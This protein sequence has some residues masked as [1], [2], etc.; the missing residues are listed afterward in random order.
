M[1]NLPYFIAR[2][3]RCSLSAGFR[4]DVLVDTPVSAHENQNSDTLQFSFLIYLL[5]M[6]R[7]ALH[8]LTEGLVMLS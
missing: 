2:T 5:Y 4:Q 8:F 7:L 1:S 6:S 3:L